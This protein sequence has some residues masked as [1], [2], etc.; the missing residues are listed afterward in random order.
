M[1]TYHLSDEF[2]DVV[3]EQALLAS[4]AQGPGLY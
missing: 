1:H 3:A 2:T 4:L